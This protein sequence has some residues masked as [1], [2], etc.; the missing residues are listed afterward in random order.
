MPPTTRSKN[1]P[2][3]GHG[4]LDRTGA[5]SKHEASTDEP[6]QDKKTTKKQK[7]IEETVKNG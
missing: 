5:G 2:R 7:T 1:Q 6:E 3:N 4:S